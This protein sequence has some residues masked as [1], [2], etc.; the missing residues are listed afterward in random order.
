MSWGGVSDSN[1]FKKAGVIPDL[2]IEGVL[3]PGHDVPGNL[4]SDVSGAFKPPVMPAV[5]PLPNA[6]A[7]NSAALR[8]AARLEADRLRKR[9]GMKS[10]IMTAGDSLMTPV[11][12]QK[13]ELLG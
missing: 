4:W 12:T 3:A 13:A 6:T 5:E 8:E 9:R 11:Q 2:S 1:F 10:T 7:D